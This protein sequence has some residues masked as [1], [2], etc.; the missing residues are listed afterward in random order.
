V[1]GFLCL[2]S[3]FSGEVPACPVWSHAELLRCRRR[4]RLRR[5]SA[6]GLSRQAVQS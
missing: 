2:R 1:T 5:G 6:A 3:L 4:I